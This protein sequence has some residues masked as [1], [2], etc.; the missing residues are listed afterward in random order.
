M[1]HTHL[2]TAINQQLN[3]SLPENISAEQL[4]KEL[5]AYIN[6]L[7]LQNFERL[8]SLLYRIDVSEEKV[9]TLLQQNPGDTA[10]SI[11]ASL[12]IERQLQ[13]IQSRQQFKTDGNGSEAEKW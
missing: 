9:K 8:V 1:E 6:Q 5:A 7:I 13:K 2:V 4:H 12:I 3:V 10:G 11:I